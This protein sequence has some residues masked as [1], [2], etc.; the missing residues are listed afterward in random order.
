MRPKATRQDNWVQLGIYAAALLMPPLALGAAF[1]SMLA[2]P[3][4]VEIPPA[5]AQAATVGTEAAFQPSA[6]KLAE[7]RP[8]TPERLPVQG[9]RVQAAPFQVETVATAPAA[10]LN[11]PAAAD[12]RP[13]PPAAD[14]PPAAAAKRTVQRR[15]H[16]QPDPYPVRTWLQGI[17][18][19][20]G[21]LPRTGKDGNGKD[22][23]G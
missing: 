22:V 17:G 2:E 16:P 12:S 10:T 9:S 3:G 5:A 6:G 23:R 18:Q 20:I 14:S 7:G 11:P 1:Y 4:E 8:Q 13:T 21:I 15:R 19:D